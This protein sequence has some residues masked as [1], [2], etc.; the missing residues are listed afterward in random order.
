MR[1][2]RGSMPRPSRAPKAA[3]HNRRSKA[4]RPSPPPRP[5]CAQ[6]PRSAATIRVRADRGR[7]TS[8]ATGRSASFVVP[9]QAGSN[10]FVVIPDKPAQRA[11]SGTQCR[12]SDDT[13]SLSFSAR[14]PCGRVTFSCLAKRK[15]PKRRPPRGRVFRTS[16]CSGFARGRR[17]SPTAHPWACGELARFLCAILRTFP[18]TARRVRGARLARV[19]R[20]AS[21]NGALVVPMAAI[22]DLA[23]GG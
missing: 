8:T 6:A 17:G 12:C 14:L 2:R 13:T 7:S 4:P 9:A 3:T 15:S 20:A 11:R 19:L 22:H 16:M 21:C 10:I 23:S 5:W 1:N 18:S